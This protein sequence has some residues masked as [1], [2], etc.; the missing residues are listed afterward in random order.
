MVGF[1]PSRVGDQPFADFDDAVAW[2]EADLGC[3]VDDF[4]VRPLV[5]VA[6]DVIGDLQNKTP[7]ARRTRYASSKNGLNVCVRL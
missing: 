2:C 7:F 1:L 5:A 3:G 4:D 6:V